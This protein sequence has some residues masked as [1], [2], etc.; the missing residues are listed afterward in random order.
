MKPYMKVEET[1][2]HVFVDASGDL[3][4]TVFTSGRTIQ[5]GQVCTDMPFTH[6]EVWENTF[7]IW[8][9]V[10]L[11]QWFHP[12]NGRYLSDHFIMMNTSFCCWG[13]IVLS[14]SAPK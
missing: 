3:K 9:P 8:N 11:R 1:S 5:Y 2:K 12:N 6:K 4:S 13:A 7:N 14:L 10:F